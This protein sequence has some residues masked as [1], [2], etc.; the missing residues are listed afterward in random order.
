MAFIGVV[1]QVCVRDEEMMVDWYTK[2]F[3]RPADEQPM[4]HLHL[5]LIQGSHG[6]Q[7]WVDAKRSGN[8]DFVFGMYDLDTERKRLDEAGLE[9]SSE[10]RDDELEAMAVSYTDPE[11]NLVTLVESRMMKEKHQACC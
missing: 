4:E 8:S 6:F 10:N 5:W 3:G 11:G 2:L 7:L 1:S 9:V